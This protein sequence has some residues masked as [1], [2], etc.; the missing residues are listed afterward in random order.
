M[1]VITVAVALNTMPVSGME[2]VPIP[3]NSG[4]LQKEFRQ[5]EPPLKAAV[6]HRAS[7][8]RY[9]KEAIRLALKELA[10]VLTDKYYEKYGGFFVTRGFIARRVNR[11]IQ[12][13]QEALCKLVE[14]KYS[15]SHHPIQFNPQT[16]QVT[17]S[18][19]Q[20]LRTITIAEIAAEIMK[21]KKARGKG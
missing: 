3:G 11:E 6:V 21:S 15:S 19:R 9:G 13:R 20:C 10:D 8:V 18:E 5:L 16:A 17:Y 12:T 4:V 1:V 14:E 2:Q 7:Q